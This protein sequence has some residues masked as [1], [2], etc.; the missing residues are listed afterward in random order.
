MNFN[1]LSN[2]VL[3]DP[4][5]RSKLA[6]ALRRVSLNGEDYVSM[7]DSI[8]LR[9]WLCQLYQIPKEDFDSVCIHELR[10]LGYKILGPEARG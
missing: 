7:T 10:D 4:V 9:N 5:I 3:A 2:K 1:E 6:A 8:S